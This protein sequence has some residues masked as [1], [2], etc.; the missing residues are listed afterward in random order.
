LKEISEQ[1][2]SQRNVID[3]DQA[4]PRKREKILLELI[5]T[6]EEGGLQIEASNNQFQ[7]SNIKFQMEIK[8]NGEI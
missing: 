2:E 8:N 7:E 5:D 3:M 4:D 1:L 6:V